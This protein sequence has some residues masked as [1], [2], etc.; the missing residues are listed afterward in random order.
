MMGRAR[1]DS[2]I[3]SNRSVQSIFSA[4]GARFACWAVQDLPDGPPSALVII[5]T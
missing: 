5:S 4:G 2:L 1:F 3:Q